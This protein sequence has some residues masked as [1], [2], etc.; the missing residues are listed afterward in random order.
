[1]AD[2]G[3]FYVNDVINV[4]ND[5]GSIVKALIGRP[6]NV[7]IYTSRDLQ[8][9]ASG[10]IHN[11]DVCGQKDILPNHAVVMTGFDSESYTFKNSWSDKWGEK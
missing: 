1:M 6:L 2:T 11:P 5:D 4:D 8:F 9:Y 10:I 7:Y 3:F